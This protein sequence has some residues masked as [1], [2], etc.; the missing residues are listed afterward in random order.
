MSG[1]ATE[2]T[3]DHVAEGVRLASN[4]LRAKIHEATDSEL[5][6]GDRAFLIAMLQD[7]ALT[8]QKDLP[9]RLGKSSSYVSNYKKRLLRQG[10]IE[11]P[12]KGQLRFSLPGFR[13][14]LV[15]VEG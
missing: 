5:S 4:E 3:E 7:E 13:D 11:E 14:Y 8:N 1:L 2:I 10:V 15:D 9:A 12:L 6:A